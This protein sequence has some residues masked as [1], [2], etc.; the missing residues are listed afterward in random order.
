MSP[1]GFEEEKVSHGSIGRR[2]VPSLLARDMRETIDF[3]RDVL[4]FAVTGRCL[5]R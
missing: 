3:Y 2:V 4:G 5:P 1:S